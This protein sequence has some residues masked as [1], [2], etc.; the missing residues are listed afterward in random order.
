MEGL[1]FAAALRAN[2]GMEEVNA[3]F[4]A[5]PTTTEQILHPARYFAGEPAVAVALP[6]AAALLGPGWEVAEQNVL[7]EF[8]LLA[9]LETLGVPRRAAAGRR[10]SRPSSC[11]RARP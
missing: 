8:F 9:R 10:G 11:R 3:A 4:D 7:G 1:A 5:L 6:D 2:G